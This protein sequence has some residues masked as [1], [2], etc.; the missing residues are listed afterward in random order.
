MALSIKSDVKP[1]NTE[2]ETME[3]MSPTMVKTAND[4]AARKAKYA[5]NKQSGWQ[6]ALSMVN[7]TLQTI[8]TGM[9]TY[10]NINAMY[11][12][13]TARS[14]QYEEMQKQAELKEKI[15]TELNEDNLDGAWN[16]AYTNMDTMTKMPEYSNIL[17]N[18]AAGKGNNAV[19]KGFFALGQGQKGFINLSDDDDSIFIEKET[20]FTKGKNANGNTVYRKQVKV[21][22]NKQGQKTPEMIA[23]EQQN[24]DFLQSKD[25]LLKNTEFKSIM[26]NNYSAYQSTDDGEILENILGN[27]DATISVITDQDKIRSL[28][29][30]MNSSNTNSVDVKDILNSSRSNQQP[31]NKQPYAMVQITNDNDTKYIPLN[32]I[33]E[34]DAFG[35]VYSGVQNRLNMG[36]KYPKPKNN[37]PVNNVNKTTLQNKN[38]SDENKHAAIE[39]VMANPEYG[40]KLATAYGISPNSESVYKAAQYLQFVNPKASPEEVRSFVNS[41]GSLDD[42]VYDK[43]NG[44]RNAAEQFDQYVYGN[45]NDESDEKSIE[46][47]QSQNYNSRYFEPKG[48]RDFAANKNIPMDIKR[49]ENAAGELIT[50]YSNYGSGRKNLA[51]KL[52]IPYPQSDI[53]VGGT[54]TPSSNIQYITKNVVNKFVPKELQSDILNNPDISENIVLLSSTANQLGFN[55]KDIKE[56]VK[57]GLSSDKAMSIPEIIKKYDPNKYRELEKNNISISNIMMLMG[58]AIFG[59]PSRVYS[60]LKN[61]K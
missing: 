39:K 19:A 29:E 48:A 61:R 17:G 44:Y 10:M 31:S 4:L 28:R 8:N 46:V 40:I 45:D 60:A 35:K 20:Q 14:Y 38:F 3:K 9:Q 7:S 36:M 53:E 49:A 26:M 11:D 37:K 33:E 25:T 55:N 41:N 22:Q 18:I 24:N 21:N 56:M 43:F 42:Y 15:Q 47:T 23:R 16:L 58:S 52:N 1:I 27:T 13:I 59:T 54:N 50:P 2:Y 12:Q 34:Y 30:R 6:E 57:I 5:N 32:S 51:E